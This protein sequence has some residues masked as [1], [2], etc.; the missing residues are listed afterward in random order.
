MLERSAGEMRGME[1]ET[2]GVEEG[3]QAVVQPTRRWVPSM[4]LRIWVAAGRRL[5]TRGFTRGR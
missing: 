5:R 2:S 3:E 1:G 4:W